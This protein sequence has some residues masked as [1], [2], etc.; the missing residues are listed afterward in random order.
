[1]S[2]LKSCFVF[3]MVISTIQSETLQSIMAVQQ[4]GT[5]FIPANLVELIVTY[6]GIS[7]FISCYIRCN[8]NLKCRTIVSD[9]T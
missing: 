1:M 5:D 9:A 7:T 4:S 3:I 2:L 6:T 8:L